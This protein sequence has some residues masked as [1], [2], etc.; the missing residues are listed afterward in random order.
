M[1]EGGCGGR[2]RGAVVHVCMCKVCMYLPM[3]VLKVEVMASAGMQ[4]S[5]IEGSVA[6]FIS[7]GKAAFSMTLMICR[8][9]LGIGRRGC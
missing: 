1:E 2:G 4:S 9:L 6:R 8:W 7:G 5:D 3:Q